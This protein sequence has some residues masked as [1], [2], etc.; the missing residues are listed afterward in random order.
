MLYEVIT[1]GPLDKHQIFLL[2]Q[3]F[4][5]EVAFLFASM[6]YRLPKVEQF[7]ILHQACHVWW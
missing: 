4:P 5:Q 6:Q 3:E 2:N 1:Q 7:Q